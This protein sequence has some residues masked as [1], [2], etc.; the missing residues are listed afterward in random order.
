[1]LKQVQQ[2]KAPTPAQIPSYANN[3]WNYAV[4]Y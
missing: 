1:M 2:D 4:I 3:K